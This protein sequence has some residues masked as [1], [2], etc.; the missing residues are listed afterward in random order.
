MLLHFSIPKERDSII[1]AKEIIDF[2]LRKKERIVLDFRHESVC[3]V[4]SILR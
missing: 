3:P 1:T 4:K 2:N